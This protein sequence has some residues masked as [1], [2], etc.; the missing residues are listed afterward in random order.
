MHA[1]ASKNINNPYSNYENNK[2]IINKQNY[3]AQSKVPS[4]VAILSHPKNEKRGIVTT[5]PRVR[6]FNGVGGIIYFS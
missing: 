4:G 5:L 6:G 2:N 3:Q 1:K